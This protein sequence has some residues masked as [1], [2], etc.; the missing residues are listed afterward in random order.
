MRSAES[1]Y[2]PDD[3]IGEPSSVMGVYPAADIYKTI[4]RTR[5]IPFVLPSTAA[6]CLRFKHKVSVW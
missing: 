3:D 1:E 5:R 4:E 6:T 2:F